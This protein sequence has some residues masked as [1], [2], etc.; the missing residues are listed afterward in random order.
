MVV[1]AGGAVALALGGKQGRLRRWDD[2]GFPRLRGGVTHTH[3]YK[4]ILWYTHLISVVIFG[5]SRVVC[6]TC[7]AW[8]CVSEGLDERILEGRPAATRTNV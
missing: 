8:S 5:M 7:L 3:T 2:D 1:G 6:L 4:Y